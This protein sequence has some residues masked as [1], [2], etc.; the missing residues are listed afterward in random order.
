MLKMEYGDYMQWP[1]DAGSTVH[2][3]GRRFSRYKSYNNP[4]YIHTMCDAKKI[5][6]RKNKLYDG[7][8]VI[9]EKY[10]ISDW[11]KYFDI[12]DYLDEHNVD[13]IVY[14]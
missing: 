6:Q 11:K 10:K 2:G 5:W 8:Q 3:V 7:C 14:A 9:V 12:I 1:N 4:Y 13:Y